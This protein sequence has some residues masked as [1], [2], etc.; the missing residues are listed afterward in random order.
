MAANINSAEGRIGGSAVAAKVNFGC[1][2][3]AGKVTQLWRGAVSARKCGQ[4]SGQWCVPRHISSRP[5][6][7]GKASQESLILRFIEPRT[8]RFSTTHRRAK[9]KVNAAVFGCVPR[10][11]MPAVASEKQHVSGLKTHRQSRLRRA[12]GVEEQLSV[13]GSSASRPDSNASSLNSSAQ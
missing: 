10:P 13:P 1:H 9:I 7:H 11:R 6:G 4:R 12:V 8:A 2:S 3:A 5:T